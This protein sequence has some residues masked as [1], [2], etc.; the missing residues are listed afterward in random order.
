MRLAPEFRTELV[1]VAVSDV[2]DVAQHEIELVRWL[3]AIAAFVLHFEQ[4]ALLA[5]AGSIRRL[6]FRS[7]TCRSIAT[8]PFSGISRKS[9]L[10][11]IRPSPIRMLTRIEPWGM[12]NSVPSALPY[13]VRNSGFRWSRSRWKA[14]RCLPSP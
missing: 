11:R 12:L 13:L 7:A 9:A 8:R 2:A 5:E 3:W 6:I 4:V 10:M 1:I 14:S